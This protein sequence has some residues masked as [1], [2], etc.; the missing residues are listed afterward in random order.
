M[1]HYTE[2]ERKLLSPGYR[3]VFIATMFLVCLFDFA[4]R[5][6]LQSTQQT[7]K[8]ELGFNDFLMGLLGGPTFA[9]LY[10]VVG[11]PIGRLAEHRSRIRIVAVCTALWSVAT[12]W[13]G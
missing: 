12:V 13:C 7:I 2:A 5:S 10:S 3:T 8:Q 6:V 4:D 1:S 11:I 9:F